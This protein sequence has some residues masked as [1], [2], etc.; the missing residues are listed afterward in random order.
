MAPGI[1]SNDR[2]SGPVLPLPLSRHLLRAHQ[3]RLRRDDDRSLG[4]RARSGRLEGRP[5]DLRLAGRTRHR[6]GRPPLRPRRR[7]KKGLELPDIGRLVAP[8][9]AGDGGGRLRPQVR[10]GHGRPIRRALRLHVARGARFA[11]PARAA[12]P[13]RGHGRKGREQR[14]VHGLPRRP[15]PRRLGPERTGPRPQGGPAFPGGPGRGEPSRS[16]R[17][18]DRLL[19]RRGPGPARA[20]AR[21]QRPRVPRSRGRRR[22]ARP[23]RSGP[24]R[25]LG[26]ARRARREAGRPARDLA[27]APLARRHRLLRSPAR[28]REEPLE[29]HPG[30][31][32][33]GREVGR[34]SRG[35][36]VQVEHR[37][38]LGGRNVLPSG[39]RGRERGVRRGHARR[40]D[41]APGHAGRGPHGPLPSRGARPPHRVRPEPG[42][43]GRRAR[44][45]GHGHR[46]PRPI[47]VLHAGAGP[48]RDQVR[49]ERAELHAE[50]LRRRGPDRLDPESLGR[51]AVLLAFAFGP[52]EGPLLD[53]RPRLFLVPRAQHGLARQGPQLPHLRIHGR[54]RGE[55]L[56]LLHG[57]GTVHG[58]RR[59]RAARPRACGLR[60]EMERG[61]RLAQDRHRHGLR[62]VHGIRTAARRPHSRGPRRFH[63]LLG[64]RG[65][66]DGE[67]DGHGPDERRAPRSG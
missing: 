1:Q 47:V 16:A 54:A 63:R 49:L 22:E 59:Q 12:A 20:Q 32:R 50:S 13:D 44:R 25:R 9:V 23:H 29:I 64:G 5:R 14:L 8:G 39:R 18:G 21:L 30:S 62:D 6:Q 31:D 67:G 33:A 58:R 57:P 51:Q 65:G 45:L 43:T 2:R 15:P 55:G 11:S 60:R 19:R 52:G 3:P 17:G 36:A 42:E 61:L 35:G 10:D 26:P 40:L 4:D 24:R 7:R 41:R 46:H 28:R 53:G 37:A 66:F 48:G 27:P 38:G 34:P 56:S